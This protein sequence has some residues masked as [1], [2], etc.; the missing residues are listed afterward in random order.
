MIDREELTTKL[1][2]L[3]DQRQKIVANTQEVIHL[4]ESKITFLK[5]QQTEELLKLENEIRN[6]QRQLMT[7]PKPISTDKTSTYRSMIQELQALNPNYGHRMIVT[8]ELMR[9]EPSMEE[10]MK[11]CPI[12]DS[13]N[14]IL[15][16]KP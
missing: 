6:V 1:N 13:T 2:Q 7:I 8:D 4:L 12:I 15:G 14:I 5:Q 11:L 16:Q 9:P 3:Q 10:K